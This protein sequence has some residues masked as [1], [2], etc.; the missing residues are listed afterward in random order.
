MADS[1]PD[2]PSR[3]FGYD[4]DGSV[5]TVRNLTTGTAIVEAT[6]AQRA[7]F[8]DEDHTIVGSFASGNAF[9][10]VALIFPELREFDGLFVFWAIP[11]GD[12]VQEV[13]VSSDTTNGVDG[14][15][16]TEIADYTDAASFGTTVPDTYRT[17]ITSAAASNVRAVRVMTGADNFSP[18]ALHVYGDITPGETPDRLL[19][20]DEATGLEFTASRDYGDIP[21]G[22]S[23]DVTWRIKNNSASLTASTIQ[24]TTEAL[25]LASGAWYTHTL[26][27]GSTYQSSRQVASLAPATT[28]GLI[29]TRRITP[30]DETLGLH[31]GRTYLN[32]GT[33]S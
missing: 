23:E 10:P 17:K 26:P 32:V 33:W 20:I 6:P 19:F 13:E 16:T 24:Y 30:G 5:L 15:W 14:T 2:V 21:R 29:T 7:E 9:H 18:R 11:P 22:G 12:R 1:Y 28:S 31:A 25:Y 27:G 3:R 4:A 8:N